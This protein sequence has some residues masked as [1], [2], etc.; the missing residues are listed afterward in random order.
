M[1]IDII[2]PLRIPAIHQRWMHDFARVCA[3]VD[4]RA[5]WLAY[6]A[7]PVPPEIPDTDGVLVSMRESMLPVFRALIELARA[8]TWIVEEDQI[9]LAKHV[10]ARLP[11]V[12]H[13]PTKEQ[14]TSG[15][16]E[17][18]YLDF[19]NFFG[20]AYCGMVFTRVRRAGYDCEFIPEQ[21]SKTPDLVSHQAQVFIECKDTLSDVGMNRADLDVT[22]AIHT[23]IGRGLEKYAKSD[24]TAEYEQ[25]I[26]LDLPEGTVS[27]FK[28]ANKLTQE[29]M[30][31]DWFNLDYIRNGYTIQKRPWVIDNPCRVL[32]SDFDFGVYASKVDGTWPRESLWLYPQ[33]SPVQ[34]PRLKQFI[35]RFLEFQG[36]DLDPIEAAPR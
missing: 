29:R 30:Y 12:S 14:V 28:D 27:R 34:P 4:N 33:V 24:A 21:A 3:S 18:L 8:S 19:R 1:D 22:R 5:T 20:D 6:V 25:L 36:S 11:Q 31:R 9:K 26:A 35:T 15:E 17:P 10:C 32:L 13:L 7:E 23:A 2:A 16:F